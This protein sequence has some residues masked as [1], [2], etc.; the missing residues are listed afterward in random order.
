MSEVPE[1]SPGGLTR[2]VAA[3]VA[4]ASATRQRA[5]VTVLVA[6]LIAALAFWYGSSVAVNTDLRALLPKTAPSVAALDTLEARKGSA[7]RFIVAIEAPTA[8][9]A[10][11]M[12]T[13]LAETIEAWPET[14]ELTVVRDYTSLR[15]HSLYFLELD[16]LEELRDELDAERKQ[17]VARSMSLGLGGDDGGDIDVNAVSVTGGWDDPGWDQEL[18]WDDTGGDEGEAGEDPPKPGPSPEGVAGA[19]DVEPFDLERFLDEQRQTLIDQSGLEAAE[20]DVIWPKEN[21][22]GEIEWEE[23]VGRSYSNDDGTVRTIQA[24]LSKPATDVRFAQDVV[25]RVQAR[26][27]ELVAE[28]VSAQTRAEVVAA[29]NVSGEVDTILRDARRATWISALSVLAVLL[30]GFRSFRAIS[31]VGVPMA[32]AMGLTLAVAKLAFGE[33]NALTVFLFAVL[34]G[35]GVDFSVHLFALRQRQGK[36][37]DW[38]S[39]IAE[40]LRPLASTMATTSGSLAVLALAEFKAFREF[41]LISAVGVAICFVAALI[42]VPAVDTLAGPLRARSLARAEAAAKAEPSAK[43]ERRRRW[44]VRGRAVLLAAC[45]VV[46]VIGAPQLRMEKD[47]RALKSQAQKQK[48]SIA[49]GSTGGRCSKTLAFVA[50][51]PE[52]LDTV[53]DRMLDERHELLPGAIDTGQSREPWVRDVYSLRTLMPIEQA[54]KAKVI[55]EVG[56]RTNDFLAE[57]P[58]LDEEAQRHTTHLEALERLA[59][60]DPLRQD[61]LP[62]WAVE[63]FREQDGRADRI[64]HACLNIAGYHIDELIAVRGRVDDIVEGTTAQ[65]ADSRLVFADLMV[66][67]ED[68]AQRLPVIALLVIL[69]FIAFDLRDLK[70]TV[71]CFATLGLGLVLVIAVMGLW[72]LRLNFFNLVVMPAVVGLGIDASIHLWHARERSTLAATGKASLI[73]ALTTVAGF[74]G[75]LAAEHAGLR[76]IGEVGVVAIIVCVGVAFLALY[77]LGRKPSAAAKTRAE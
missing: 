67:V 69:L 77:P 56:S 38:E 5:A 63:P 12:V 76:S 62:S 42:L 54:A 52:D 22:Q 47:T 17:A 4:A 53:V 10:E 19:A 75:L 3:M 29:Y 13:G 7:E 32:V 39:V 48:A 31:L 43:L 73:A 70:S 50:D 35:M 55:A 27:A 9:D 28:G 46:A 61:E 41:G 66:L 6:V 20:V 58:D 64:A 51:T 68:D 33:L 45:A 65:P 15:N 24:S 74:S 49:Y 1:R 16:Q 44:L 30:L 71:A 2:R 36:E 21:E 59:K 26:A 18:E 60:S 8:E 23:E 25:G 72:P 37:A 11:R 57:L 14:E 40:H 34:F